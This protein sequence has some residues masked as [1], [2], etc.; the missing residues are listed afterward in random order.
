MR[1]FF[2]DIK[3]FAAAIAVMTALCATS[4]LD[5]IPGSAI[6]EKEAIKSFDD[7]KQLRVGI[8]AMLKSSALYSGYLTLLPDLQ[9]DLVYAVEGFSNNHGN[10]WQWDIRPTN[11]EIESVYAA[12]YNV[13]SNCNYYLDSI[14]EVVEN[15]TNDDNIDAMERYTGEIYTIRALAY[16]ELVKC[17]CKAYDPTTAANEKGV[18]LRTSYFK[19]E[20]IVRASLERS[21][22]FILADL[23]EAESRLDI[24]NDTYSSVGITLAA[25][26]ALHARVALNMQDWDTA[27]DYSSRLIDHPNK[28]FELANAKIRNSNGQTDFDYMWSN[29]ASFEIIWRIGFTETSYGG[30][31]GSIFLNFTTDYYNYYPD[32]VPAKWVLDLYDTN[33]ARYNSYFY[34]FTTGYNHGLQWPLLVKYYGNESFINNSLIYHVNMPKPFR[35]AE[36]YLIR[37]EAYCRAESSNYAKAAN[38]LTTLRQMRYTSGGNIN[39]TKD[40]FIEQISNER[41]RELYMEGFRLNDLKRWGNLYNEGKGFKRTPQTSSLDEGSS[42]EIKADNPLFVWPIPQHEIEAPGSQIEPNDSNLNN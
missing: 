38:D 8:Y 40:N 25:A 22:E 23:A 32:Y 19:K 9:C 5:K 28:V 29:D 17:F 16:S 37:A 10:I 11:S 1:S 6:G 3:I 34:P 26:Y 21:Y 24:E 4:C 33:D 15:E 30:A 13:I 2:N 27:I 41:V 39:I 12:L 18:V 42:L 20:P 7:V 35:L 36:Q 31:L 14:G